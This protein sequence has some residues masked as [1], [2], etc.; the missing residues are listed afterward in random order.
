M[1]KL[2]Q[3]QKNNGL[4]PDGVVGKLTLNMIKQC[5][6][7]DTEEETSHFVGQ[8]AHETGNF[9][10]EQENLNYSAEALL[11]VFSGYFNR[12]QAIE[13]AR[14]PEKIANRVYA[15]RMGN[16]DE[17]SGDGWKHRGFGAIQ[18]T[19]KKNQE[20]FAQKVRDLRIIEDPSIIAKDYYF[21]SAIFFFNENNIWK[22]C[23]EVN[24]E[25][26]LK[27]SRAINL[28]NPNSKK[29]PNGLKDRKQLTYKFYNDFK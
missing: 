17:E 12:E 8:I 20:R 16:G 15:N 2:Q 26:I 4:K 25:T 22:Y 10:Y 1:N 7:I 11:S 3:F 5:Y 28:G 27:V 24:D 6:S 23:K 19:G 29:T 9:R 13:Y 21:E 18:T 14:K